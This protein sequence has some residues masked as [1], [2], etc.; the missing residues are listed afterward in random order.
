[1]NILDE[2]AARTRERI[3][4]KKKDLPLE[5]LMESAE[6]LKNGPG[7]AAGFPF[8]RALR[9]EGVSVIC[10]IKKASPSKGVISP[11]FPYARIA[12][13]YE[14]A[15]AAA[16]SVLT[17]PFYFM[18]DDLYLRQI[19]GEVG[20]PLLRK[21][22]TVDRYMIYEAA[23]LGASAVLLICAILN[24]ETLAEFIG[25]AH[26]LGL[27]ALVE[28]HDE[29]EVDM[30]LAAGARVIGVN[31]RDL[32]TFEVD[33]ALTER[34]RG[35]VPADRLFVSESG[36]KGPDDMEKLRRIGADAALVG[37]ALMRSADRKAGLRRLMGRG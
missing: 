9:G 15:G 25:T 18:G 4:A 30:A 36:V 35:M 24:D 13:E 21:D 26:D 12:K 22:F 10:E 31:N 8:E 19:A 29:R 6:S 16:I 11:D 14:E 2:I 1:M 23:L 7:F 3:N 27:S 5:L 33:F 28:V 20:I 37:E 17:E 34:L 32:R